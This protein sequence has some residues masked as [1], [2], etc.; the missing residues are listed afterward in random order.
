MLSLTLNALLLATTI[1]GP[2]LVSA[3]EFK[4]QERPPA[5][6]MPEAFNC[7]SLPAGIGFLAGAMV[8]AG[9]CGCGCAFGG[10]AIALR[11]NEVFAP[12]L[13]F[14]TGGAMLFGASGALAGALLAPNEDVPFDHSPE[15]QSPSKENTPDDAAPPALLPPPAPLTSSMHY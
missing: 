1:S 6:R 8:G 10:L 3:T 4:S 13:F 15:D 5:E 11:P 2:P 12:A 7:I 14:G 9:L